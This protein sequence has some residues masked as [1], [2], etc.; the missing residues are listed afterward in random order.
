MKGLNQAQIQFYKD[1]GYLIVKDVFKPSDFQPLIDE[2]NAVVNAGAR[3]YYEQ[4]IL[5]DLFE[6]EPF[7]RRLYKIYEAA[8]RPDEVWRVVHSKNHKT[9]GMFAM[10]THTAILDIVESM[11]GPEIFVHPQFNS[12]V[13]LPNHAPTVVPWHQ[14]LGYLEPD[15]EE[16]FMVNF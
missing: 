14:D 11:I 1:N 10:M 15:A 5:K 6:D 9:T 3:K 4:G 13:K 12:R 2:F 8:G 16:T 7:S